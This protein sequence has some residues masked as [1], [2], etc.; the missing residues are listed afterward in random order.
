MR[1]VTT[2][3]VTLRI[4]ELIVNRIN[5]LAHDAGLTHA[6]VLRMLLQRVSEADLPVSLFE[7]ADRLRAARGVTE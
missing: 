3:Q 6:Q 5:G 1:Q 2:G 4:P 7:N